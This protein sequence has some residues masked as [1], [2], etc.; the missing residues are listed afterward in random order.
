MKKHDRKKEKKLAP[1]EQD[2]QNVDR[3]KSAEN[4][5]EKMKILSE[6]SRDKYKLEALEGI[7]EIK[8]CRYI[9]K[10]RDVESILELLSRI[11]NQNQKKNVFANLA[12]ELKGNALKYL[13]ILAGVDFV[14]YVP[15]TMRTLNLNNLNGL[16]T[17]MLSRVRKNISSNLPSF[18]INDNQLCSYDK[19][20]EYTFEE[21]FAIVAKMEELTQGIEEKDSEDDKFNKI[22]SRITS[23]ITYDY[24]GLEEEQEMRNSLSLP[25]HRRR[26]KMGEIRHNTAGLYGGLVNGTSIC[27]GY[28]L[29]THEALQYVGM[30]SKY[31]EGYTETSGHAWIQVRINGVWLNCDPTWDAQEVQL[32]RDRKYALKSDKEFASS[33]GKYKVANYHLP[34]KKTV[35]QS[36]VLSKKEA[37]YE[38]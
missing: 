24:E 13:Q 30:K 8:L 35:A 18:K 14:S 29:I 23:N 26:R 34:C 11:K 22:Y 5:E 4:Q 9:G 7:E 28:A 25:G 37:Q 36:K 32:G 17:D 38:H 16:T 10:L 6:I 27:A 3:F 20:I 15:V 2:I 12:Y 33:H 31:I 19:N 1:E 21:M